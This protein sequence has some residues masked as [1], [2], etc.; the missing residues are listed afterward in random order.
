MESSSEI[1]NGIRLNRDIFSHF[2]HFRNILNCSFN[3]KLEKWET[4]KS[5]HFGHHSCTVAAANGFVYIADGNS[6][7]KGC[8]CTVERYDP[9]TDEWMKVANLSNPLFDGVLLEWKGFLYA[10]DVNERGMERYDCEQN[11]WVTII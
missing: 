10:V 8:C 5:M 7:N 6:V 1:A 3:M 4:L 9:I 11:A 2:I